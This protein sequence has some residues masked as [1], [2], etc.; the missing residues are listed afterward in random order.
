MMPTFPSPP[1]KFRTAGFP[2]YGFKASRSDRAFLNGVSVK[3][4]PGIP[5]QPLSLP[6]P[7]AHFCR[8]KAPG[9]ES[10]STRASVCRCSRGPAPPL[11]QGSLAP[12]RVMLSRS[13]VAYYDPIR[14]SHRHAATSRPGRLYAAPSLCG[15]ASATRGTFPTF[16]AVPSMHVVDPTPAGPPYPPVILTRRFQASSNYHRVATREA[17]L[18]QQCPTGYFFSG[19]H[20][21]LYATT[22]AFAEPS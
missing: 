18:C 9:S 15:S 14:Q 7:F 5:S 21:S 13:I 4:A 22:C 20:R 16:A 17:R 19:L 2:R 11:P 6:P 8:G 3:P 10:R 12:A 1:L